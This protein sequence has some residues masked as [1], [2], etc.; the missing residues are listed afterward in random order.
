MV[1]RADKDSWIS[2]S[3]REGFYTARTGRY[4]PTTYTYSTVVPTV[5]QLVAYGLLDHERMPPGHLGRQSRFRAS[6]ELIK[7]LDQSPFAV[8]HDPREVVILR[9]KNGDLIDYAETER[10]SRLRHNVREINDAILSAAIGIRGRTICEGNPIEVGGVRIGAASNRLHRVFNRA[11]FSNGGRFYG[12][13][14]QNIRSELRADITLNG[15]QTIEMDYPRLHPTLMYAEVGKPMRGDPYDLADWPR[16]LVKVAFNTMV[17]ADTPQAAM[18]SIANE[19]GGAGALAKA[20]TLVREIEAKHK[21]VAHMFGSGA[22][23]RLMRVDSDMTERLLLRLQKR[24]VVALP[25]HDSYIV[26]DRVADKGELLEGMAEALHKVVGNKSNLSVV[27]P[28][29]LPQYGEG[30]GGGGGGPAPRPLDGAPRGGVVGCIVVFFP[31]PQQ[32]DLFGPISLEMPVS[33]IFGWRGGL[34]PVG[35]QTALRHEISRRGLRHRDMARRCQIS[36]RQF[37]N[38]LRGRLRASQAVA[39]R[40][41]DFLIEGARTVGMAA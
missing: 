38:V 27:Y 2:Y 36:P 26:P 37:G 16:D 20:Q 31:E 19:I 3:R 34:A 1:G 39:S 11:S 30:V 41:R 21:A 9:D 28:K 7:F 12:P 35:V 40:I 5:D 18:R 14:W 32:L 13:W 8:V 23:L 25:I 4:W 17:N 10:S 22:G 29:S 6:N 24:G 15:V 33:D